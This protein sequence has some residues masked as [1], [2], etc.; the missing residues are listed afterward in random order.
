M[1]PFGSDAVADI[2][3]GEPAE[4]TLPSAGLVS[5]TWGGSVVVSTRMIFTAAEVLVAF[6]LFVAFAVIE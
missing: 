1:V 6:W 2:E 5:F 4:K 3:I